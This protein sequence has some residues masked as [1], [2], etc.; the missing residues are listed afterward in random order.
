MDPRLLKYY[1]RELTHLR[2][3][4]GEFAAEF[5]KIAGRLSLDGIECADPYVERLLEGFAFLAA[6]VQLRLDAEFPK[7]TQHLFE[8]VYPHYVSPTPSMAVARMQPDL[9]EGSLA[10][11]YVVPRGTSLHGVLGKGE[12][13]S[14]E[15]RTAHDVTLWPLELTEAE[16]ASRDGA[17]IELPNIAGVRAIIRLRLKSTAGL[18]MSKLKL[19]R[20]PIFIH[21]AGALPMQLYEQ[22][23]SGCLGVIVRPPSRQFPWQSIL[24]A[25]K[26]QPVGFSDEEALLPFGPRSFQGYRLL[27]EYFAC[28]QR[29]MFFEVS[30]LAPSLAKTEGNELEIILL[31]DRAEPQLETYVGPPN[32]A[33]FA[34]PAINLFPKTA[35]RIHLSDQAHEHH[36]IPDR[37]RPLDF[38]VYEITSCVGYGTELDQQQV[39]LPFY[40]TSDHAPAGQAGAYFT[41]HRAPRVLSTNQRKYG[42]RSSYIGSEIFLSLVDG[43]EAP[44]HHDLRQLTVSTL[45]TNRDL[46]LLMPVGKGKTDFLLE[47]GAPVE[48]VRCLAGPT[49]PRASPLFSDGDFLW[50]LVSH[51]TLNYLSI[52]DNDERKGAAALRDLLKLYSHVDDAPTRKQI[53]GVRNVASKPITRRVP[54]SGPITFGR[55][56]EITVTCDEAAFEGTGVYLLGAVLERFFAR[57]VSLNSFT[58]T[59]L[60]TVD[61]GQVMR[62]PARI[63]RRQIA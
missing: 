16:Y 36:V 60:A 19:D 8:M 42:P 40:A 58:E 28:P 48:S 30:G 45:C 9:K 53:E 63:G 50:R 27:A 25:D 41:L 38:E 32:F 18:P 34:T 35:D 22:I 1:E 49:R 14:C 13:T 33:L 54:T 7:F 43:K 62:W 17:G 24:R 37:T 61:R 23:M 55:G 11:G 2:E 6:R 51:L 31:L 46:A 10:D 21:G 56:L 15:Y 4:G 52:V 44:Y 59:V 5:P 39:F 29:F 12:T 20:L 57:Y 26:V 3:M 47:I